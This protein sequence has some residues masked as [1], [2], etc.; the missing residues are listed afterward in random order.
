[1]ADD[2]SRQVDA[3]LAK[4]ALLVQPAACGDVCVRRDRH[5]CLAMCLR[6][7]AKHAFDATR[8]SFGVGRALQHAGAHA[9]LANAVGDVLHEQ[10]GH[11]IGAAV[12]TRL[13]GDLVGAA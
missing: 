7:G 6:G 12:E 10:V 13:I 5:A 4:D 8:E 1:M 11:R 2:D 9:G 3:F